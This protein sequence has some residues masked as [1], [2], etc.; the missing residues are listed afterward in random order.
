MEVC[1]SP[2]LHHLRLDHH[3]SAAEAGA[4]LAVHWFPRGSVA[5]TLAPRHTKRGFII[6][7]HAPT[8]RGDRGV[9]ENFLRG[10]NNIMQNRR[11]T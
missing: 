10:P 3:T 4:P 9:G 5:A 8:I 11:F 1:S 7:G 2:E 6:V